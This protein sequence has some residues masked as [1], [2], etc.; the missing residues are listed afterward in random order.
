MAGDGTRGDRIGALAGIV[1]HPDSSQLWFQL[2][3]I[4]GDRQYLRHGVHVSEGSVVLDVGAN[5]GVA[6][7]FFASQCGAGLVHCFEP[8]PPVCDILRENVS[9]L[10]ACVVHQF[11]LSSAAGQAEFTYYPASA[12]M[13][14]QYADPERDRSAVRTVLENLGMSDDE[15]EER[16]AGRWDAVTVTCELRTLSSFLEEEGL[17]RVDLL[18]IDVER[19]ERDVLA[20]VGERDWPRIRQLA[21][22][23]HDEDGRLGELELLL[24]E[25]GFRTSREQAPPMR[26][27]DVHMLYATRP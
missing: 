23:V 19:A 17:E 10:P 1:K 4:A 11:G 5:V 13:S 2:A 21:V 9:D 8:V 14:G 16:L 18:K 27:T 6:A 25:R 15:A 20:G 7:V 22:E 24:A 3:E 12:A 26:N